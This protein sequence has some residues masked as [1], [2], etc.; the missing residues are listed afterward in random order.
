MVR[1][2]LL[3]GDVDD[4]DQFEPRIE[5][6]AMQQNVGAIETRVAGRTKGAAI[7]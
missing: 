3:L 5:P 4:V 1:V 6:I 2:A 7:P